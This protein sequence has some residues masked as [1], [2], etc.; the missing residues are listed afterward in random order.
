VNSSKDIVSGINEEIG[1]DISYVRRK[2]GEQGAA[3]FTGI[4]IGIIFGGTVLAK[5][6]IGMLKGAGEEVTTAAGK[7]VGKTLAKK[8]IEK[9]TPIAD[10]TQFKETDTKQRSKAA[11]SQE[12]ELELVRTT[13]TGEL[14]KSEYDTMAKAYSAGG[15]EV[16]SAEYLRRAQPEY[17]RALIS[18]DS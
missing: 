17:Y 8:L 13:L 3:Y 10:E 9:L 7:Q 14:G 5:F 15:M 12:E 18:T 1:A 2:H 6:L 4:E 16:E 11:E